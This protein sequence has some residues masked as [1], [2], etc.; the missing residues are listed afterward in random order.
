MR[1]TGRVPLVAL[2]NKSFT[3][4]PVPFVQTTVEVSGT[5]LVRE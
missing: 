1:L 3:I 5:A 2:P 4:R